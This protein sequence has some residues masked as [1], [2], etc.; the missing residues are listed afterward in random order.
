[1]L[2]VDYKMLNYVYSI[3][4]ICFLIFDLIVCCLCIY[5][6]YTLCGGR[7]FCIIQ[8][9]IASK[10]Q[11]EGRWNKHKNRQ[12]S[13]NV[14]MK[15]HFSSFRIWGATSRVKNWKIIN[16]VYILCAG[17]K[18]YILKNWNGSLFSCKNLYYTYGSILMW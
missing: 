9:K 17:I 6:W 18:I 12:R 11:T 4:S 5:I 3:K 2:Y 13:L 16:V 10:G 7:N 1:M 8:P 15:Y 14:L